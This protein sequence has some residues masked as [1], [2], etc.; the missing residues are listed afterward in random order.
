MPLLDIKD[1]P[2]KIVKKNAV[3]GLDYGAKKIGLALSDRSWM[4][5]SPYKVITN[6][7]FTFVSEQIFEI[8]DEEKIEL[9]VI[10]IPLMDD[11]SIN[12]THQAAKQFGRNLIKV[13]DINIAFFNENYTSQMADEIML[14]ADLTRQKRNKKNDKIAASIMLQRFLTEFSG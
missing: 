5:A 13:K 11:G 6:N 14:Q 10:G 9:L 1:I 4:I 12:K 7:K 2:Q 3:L 8:I